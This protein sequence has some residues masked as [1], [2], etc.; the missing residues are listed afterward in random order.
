MANIL[1]VYGAKSY[2]LR[3]TTE[4]HLYCFRRYSGHRCFYF[5]SLLLKKPWYRNIPSFLRRVHFDLIIFYLDMLNIQWPPYS[6]DKFIA[7][8]EFF[9][10]VNAVKVALAQ[11]E[12]YNTDL[13]N[14]FI[15]ELKIN[16]VF[17]LAP[18]SEWSKI[19]PTVDFDRVKFH[20]ALPGYLD[21]RRLAE[22]ARLAEG[23][24][25]RPIAIGYRAVRQQNLHWLGRHG[26]K[27]LEIADL[28]D[29]KASESGIS[30]DISTNAADALL[31]N[32]WYRFLLR[33]KYAIAVEGGASILDHNGC[34]RTKTEAYLA[35]HP[36]ASF[37]EVEQVCFLGRDGEL[38]YMSISPKHLEACATKTCQILVEGTYNGILKPGV[39]YL[40]LKS[41]FSNVDQVLS[42]VKEDRLRPQLVERAYK[43]IVE[44]GA[45]TYQ[46]FVQWVLGLTLS[47]QQPRSDDSKDQQSYVWSR[48]FENYQWISVAVISGLLGAVRRFL[49]TSF[50]S[51]LRRLFA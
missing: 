49:P 10:E 4:D 32:D 22:I 21:E 39:H 6:F 48:I 33:S 3:A 51:F 45:Y 26:F 23:E 17:S 16:H 15:C 29:R 35:E 2:P 30:A 19:Y 43:D 5:N 14:Q 1:V 27:K 34:V 37:D 13:L 11:D 25:D 40:E 41:D 12:F 18:S 8:S 50:E 36:Q 28:F 44:S 24:K 46:S 20:R 9:K 38:E 31:G 47:D 42:Q 7:Q